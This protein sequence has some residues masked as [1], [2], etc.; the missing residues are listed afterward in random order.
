M[1]LLRFNSYLLRVLL[2]CLEVIPYHWQIWE[3]FIFDLVNRA[4]F[5]ILTLMDD[6]ACAKRKEVNLVAH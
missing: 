2:D 4:K 6:H 5:P 3:V 1:N